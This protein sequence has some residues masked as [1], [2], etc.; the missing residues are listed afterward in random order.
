MDGWN[1]MTVIVPR[2]DVVACDIEGGRALLDLQ[3]SKYYKLNSTASFLWNAIGER[4][5]VD[6]LCER[7]LENYDVDTEHCLPDVIAILQSFEKA[8]LVSRDAHATA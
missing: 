6:R 8:G 5:S 7:L 1:Q 4:A 2:G 3:S